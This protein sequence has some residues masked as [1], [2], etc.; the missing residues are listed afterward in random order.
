MR[1]WCL[2]DLPLWGS[3]NEHPNCVW[4]INKELIINFHLEN[5]VHR[6]MKD[7]IK[8]LRFL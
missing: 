4:T 6:A 8:L 7:S 5:A 2:L 3:S 1:L